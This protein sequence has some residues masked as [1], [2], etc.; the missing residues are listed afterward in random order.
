MKTKQ[1]IQIIWTY[2]VKE[3][4]LK[5]FVEAYSPEGA[6]AGLFQNCPGYIK[7]DLKRDPANALRF[8]TIDYWESMSAYAAM[9]QTVKSAYEALDQQCDAYTL[10]EEFVG[11]FED[12]KI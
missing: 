6:W 2:T 8:L 3:A 5:K 4:Y 11:I 1:K 9:K 12:C 7:T 10:A